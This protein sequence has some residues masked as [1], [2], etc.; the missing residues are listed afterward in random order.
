MRS[1]SKRGF[2]LGEWLT[3]ILV[4][5]ASGV[6]WT[7]RREEM[8]AEGGS[9]GGFSDGLDGGSLVLRGLTGGVW[10]IWEPTRF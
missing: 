5:E 9:L 8:T 3:A 6:I 1:G 10:D 4:R 7:G 2:E